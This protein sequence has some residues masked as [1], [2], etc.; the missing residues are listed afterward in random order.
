MAKSSHH[1]C[2]R[3]CGVCKPHKKWKTNS[4]G[5][6][7]PSVQRR[8]TDLTDHADEIDLRHID[9][10]TRELISCA[11]GEIAVWNYLPSSGDGR[12]C[13]DECVPR[14]CCD[15]VMPDGTVELD[16]KGRSMACCE[17]QWIGGD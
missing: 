11:C 10:E 7:K 6:L 9:T 5:D 13:C 12:P 3:S 15:Y 1:G 14:G 2:G 4:T 17:Y 16:E 8:I